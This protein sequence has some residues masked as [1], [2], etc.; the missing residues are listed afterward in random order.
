MDTTKQSAAADLEAYLQAMRLNGSSS[1]LKQQRCPAPTSLRPPQPQPP[2][3][4]VPTA[5]ADAQQLLQQLQE[6][7]Q[8]WPQPQPQS[9]GVGESST[10]AGYVSPFGSSSPN[11]FYASHYGAHSPRFNTPTAPFPSVSAKLNAWAGHYS[12]IGPSHPSVS[13]WS[14]MPSSSTNHCQPTPSAPQLGAPFPAWDHHA[15]LDPYASALLSALRPNQMD[16]RSWIH[17]PAVRR[18]PTLEE[19]RSRL[20]R[21][22][23]EPELVMFPETAGHVV[24]L[25]MEGGEEVRLSVL[26][27]VKRTVR[28]VIGCGEGHAVFLALLRA[29]EGRLDELQG[30]VQAVCKGTGFLMHVVKYNHG[31]TA[32]EELI[33]AVA[34]HQQLCLP[35]IVW[36]LRER[37]MEHSKGAELLHHCFTTMPYENCSIMIRFAIINIDEMLSSASGS[38]CLAECFRNAQKDE[39][40]LLEE[41]ILSRTSEIARGE[42][43]NYF[44]QGALECGSELLTDR[45]A[46]RVAEDVASLS[47]DQ[48]GS[49]VVEACFLRTLS[50]APAQRVLAAFLGLRNDQLAELVQGGYSNYVVHKLLATG[51]DYF[52]EQTTALA[53]RIEKLPAAVQRE[54]HAQRV[55]RVVK[56]LFPRQPRY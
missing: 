20:L 2:K 45:I 19:V 31:V 34:L 36:L 27:G 12:P 18:R 47:A 51:K 13:H 24:R 38:R 3:V 15:S 6:V 55:M 28:S 50:L 23:M 8:Y 35:L 43:S 16:Y 29:C 40:R 9:Y 17:T 5:R 22:P 21:R 1:P 14:S 44:L 33:R 32:L 49:Y 25:L 37:L 10:G 56:K 26:A 4:P 11:S 46:E 30:I 42:Y 39:L 48:F 7:R 54:M 52:P 41:I 53:R